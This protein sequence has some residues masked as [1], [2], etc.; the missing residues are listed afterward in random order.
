MMDSHMVCIP[1]QIDALQVIT[2]TEHS[3]GRIGLKQYVFCRAGRGTSSV[4]H[5]KAS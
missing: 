4:V 1:S 2:R 3:P 5:V